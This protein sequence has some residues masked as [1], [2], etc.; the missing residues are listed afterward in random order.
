MEKASAG[1]HWPGGQDWNL[2]LFGEE[3]VPERSALSYRPIVSLQVVS[4]TPSV[5]VSVEQCHRN[6]VCV[7]IAYAIAATA[8][9][10]ATKMASTFMGTSEGNTFGNRITKSG[11]NLSKLEWLA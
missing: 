2:H 6:P 9:A 4:L 5:W 11:A 1:R 3:G 10:A 7:C 8:S